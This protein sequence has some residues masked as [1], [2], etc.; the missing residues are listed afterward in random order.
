MRLYLGAALLGVI[1]SGSLGA[2]A[3]VITL[4]TRLPF[5]PNPGA[6]SVTTRTTTLPDGSVSTITSSVTLPPSPSPSGSVSVYTRTT[7]LPNGSALTI[8]GSTTLPVS[9]SG[10]ISVYTHT[11]T[12]PDGSVSTITGSTTLP[13]SP[14]GSVSLVTRTTTLP[15][16]S[17]ST[18]TSSTTVP[19]PPGGSTPVTTYTTTGPGGSITVVT[20]SGTLA[21]TPAGSTS[22]STFVT[23]N[24]QGSLIT[25]TRTS[26]IP[27]PVSSSTAP[28]PSYSTACTGAHSYNDNLGFVWHVDCGIDYPGY[29]LPAVTVSSFELCLEACDNYVP[30]ADISNGATC[31][32]AS[33][34]TRDNGGECYLKYYVGETR[35]FSGFDSANKGGANV[36]TLAPT[37]YSVIPDSTSAAQSTVIVQSSTNNQGSVVVSSTTSRIS[38]PVAPSTTVIVQS[39]TNNQGSVVVSSTASTASNPI[40]STSCGGTYRDLLGVSWHV[41]CSTAYPGNDLPAVTVTSFENCLEACDNYTPSQT[42]ANG[43]RCFAVTYGIR[44]GGGECYLKSNI[45]ETL[46]IGGQDSAYKIESGVRPPIS[47]SNT[48]VSPTPT[49]P[50]PNTT[51][52]NTPSTV[53]TPSSSSTPTDPALLFQPCPR[54]DGQTF[55]DRQGTVYDV[56]CACEYPGYDLTTPHYDSFQDCIDACDNYNP[57]P[58]VA[59]GQDCVAATWSYGNPGGNCYLKYAIGEIRYGNQNDCSVKLHNYTIPN[60]VSSTSTSVP[61]TTTSTSSSTS[62]SSSSSISSSSSSGSSSSSSTSSSTSTSPPVPATTT[63]SSNTATTTIPPQ[64]SGTATCPANRGAIYTDS[65]GQV[66][67]IHCG[68]QVDG[69]NAASAFH[70]DSFEKCVNI[71][72]VLGGCTSVTYPGE[73]DVI[74]NSNCYPY[75]SFRFYSQ[76]AVTDTL[77]SARVYNGSTSPN[78]ANSVQVCPSYDN[79]QFRDPIGRTYNVGCNQGFTTGSN[80]L[81]STVMYTLEA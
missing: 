48:P 41:D 23:T 68:Q 60:S 81:Y 64:I 21:P 58:N 34:G 7:T 69:D 71:C 14:S 56:S 32:G 75:T 46:T 57:D 63:T 59:G 79:A 49:T 47:T 22:V 54:S 16:G 26:V 2:L 43:A 42:V 6:V 44:T 74:G 3:E 62:S 33:Y 25:T 52:S 51:P 76:Q 18:L 4:T 28:P 29:D 1:L 19:P 53:T 50:P 37:S 24:S 40:Y 72:E 17:V 65:Y 20:S 8:T 77:L 55:I 73:T 15:D 12:L 45:T 11:T 10:S 35:Y 31:V 13:V 78:F 9:P 5:C 70:A 36:V 67:E 38:T 80:D 61:L 66:Y 39:S 30:R 27:P